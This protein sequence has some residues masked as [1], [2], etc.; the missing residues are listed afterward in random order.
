MREKEAEARR[1]ADAL[2]ASRLAREQ[3]SH[4][5]GLSEVEI[6]KAVATLTEKRDHVGALE[7]TVHKAEAQLTSAL[8]AWEAGMTEVHKAE[9]EVKAARAAAAQHMETAEHHSKLMEKIEKDA[10]NAMHAAKL[11]REAFPIP[12][13]RF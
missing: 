3:A 10:T 6:A 9:A 8:A 5:H 11:A 2:A 13:P 4:A 1:H 7:K 12:L